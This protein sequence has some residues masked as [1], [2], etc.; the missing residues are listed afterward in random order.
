MGVIV[1]VLVVV[2]VEGVDEIEEVDVDEG[3]CEGD[4]VGGEL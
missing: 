3:G 2:M 1:G 4:E